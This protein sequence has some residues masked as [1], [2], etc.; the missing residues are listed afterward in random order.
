MHSY[1]L[2][3]YGEMIADRVRMEAYAEALRKTV[4]PGNV[5]MDLG[6]GPGV[7]AVL[8]CELGASRVVAVEPDSIIQVAREVAISSQCS[9]RIEFIEKISTSLELP[10]QADVIVSDMRGVLPL[11]GQ[12]VLSVVDARRRFLAPRGALIGRSDV[13]WV[14][15][16]EAPKTYGQLADPWE[17]NLLKQDL[18]TARRRAVNAPQKSRAS[19]SQLLAAPKVWVTLDYTTIKDPNV[20][21]ELEWEV[22]RSG[23]GH[24]FLAWFDADLTD[25]VGFSNAPGAPETIYGSQFFPWQNPVPLAVGQSVRLKLDAKF[26]QDDYFWRW[27][28]DIEPPN[29]TGGLRIHFEQSSLQGEVVSLEALQKRASVYVPQLSEEGR[30][31]RRTLDMMDGRASLEDIARRLAAEFPLRFTQWQQA[32]SYAGTV[33]EELGD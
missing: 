31:R 7:W 8:A 28:T 18:S 23:T 2:A 32:L 14:A 25:G 1:S 15:L 27:T 9:D 16:V 20:Q 22:E 11:Y 33:S 4:K 12:N 3:G 21:G 17:Y 10:I 5:V 29:G 24:G 30:I 13:L 6:S 26:L 19:P